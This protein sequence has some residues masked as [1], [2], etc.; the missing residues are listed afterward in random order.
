M[1]R[2]GVL[3]VSWGCPNR[4]MLG[5]GPI[6]FVRVYVCTGVPVYRYTIVRAYACT[7]VP[8]YRHFS[9]RVIESRNGLEV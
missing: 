9:A 5:G 2:G 6:R 8:V 3:F 7:C 4:F 1:A